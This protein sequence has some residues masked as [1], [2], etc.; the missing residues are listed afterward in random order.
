[1]QAGALLG[2]TVPA[3]AR[4]AGT[5]TNAR[6][7]F[8]AASRRGNRDA[9]GACE[10]IDVLLLHHSNPPPA[11]RLHQTVTNVMT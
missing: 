5:F 11:S 2:S 9:D 4:D 8:W 1:M 6:E 3:Q 7:T 10:L